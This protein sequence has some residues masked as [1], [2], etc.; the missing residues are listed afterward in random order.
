[1]Y[2]Y[3]CIYI[4]IYIYYIACFRLGIFESFSKHNKAG[5]FRLSAPE[6]LPNKLLKFLLA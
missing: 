1:M 5:K 2:I 4:Y 6:L 3:I